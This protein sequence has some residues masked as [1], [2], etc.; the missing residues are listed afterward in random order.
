M[1]IKDCFD[2]EFLMSPEELKRNKERTQQVLE[3]LASKFVRKNKIPKL[4]YLPIPERETLSTFERETDHYFVKYTPLDRKIYELEKAVEDDEE[5]LKEYR[6]YS[7]MA[8][9]SRD[10]ISRNKPLLKWLRELR[11]YRDLYEAAARDMEDPR[12]DDKCVGWVFIKDF[13]EIYEEAKNDD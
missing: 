5:R 8:K 10:R 3:V 9:I 13:Q 7:E 12:S 1:D 6:D 2:E 4:D 11:M